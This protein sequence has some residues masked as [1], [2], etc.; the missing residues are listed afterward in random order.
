MMDFE[1]A[2]VKSFSKYFPKATIKGCLFHFGQSLHK[3]M[4]KLQLSELYQHNQQFHKWIRLIF[5]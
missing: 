1:R 3:K 2:A 5:A 4:K